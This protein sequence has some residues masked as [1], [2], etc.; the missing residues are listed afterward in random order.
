MPANLPAEARAKWIKVME[1]K[2]KEEKLRA[3]QEFLSC[4]PR[5]KGT[6]KLIKQVRR[7]IA[8]LRRE[9]EKERVKKSGRGVGHFVKKEGAAQVLLVGLTN[10]GKSTI[11]SKLTN[12][13]PKISNQPFTT[14][15]PVAGMMECDGV[16]FQLVEG[17]A[18][19][20]GAS[21]GV[22]YGNLTLAMARNA[23]VLALV[24]DLSYNPVYQ[25]KVI[26][27]ELKKSGIIL[28]KPSTVV[29]IKRRGKGG[30][31]IV[32]N[33]RNCSYKDVV[34]LLRNYGIHHAY[35]KITGEASLDDIEEAIQE[36][37]IYK[38]ALVIATK[39][40]VSGSE[41]RLNELKRALSNTPLL[42]F[43]NYELVKVKIKDMLLNMLDLI[44]VYTRNSV[45]KE[46]AEKPIIVKIGTT[47][48]EVARIIHSQLYEN[49][50]CAKVWRENFGKRPRRVGRNFVL[51][52][53]DIVE[54]I[55]R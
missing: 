51:E 21:D 5:H 9:L 36:E 13:S 7:Q 18:I 50:K 40:D 53:G 41:D 54:I 12:A 28:E 38:P 14:K 31:V 8:I 19:V 55:A 27:E 23:D 37:K 15:K 29:T 34:E 22:C 42:I 44:R 30:I 49:F 4:V 33:L 47:V 10:S 46:I 48:I 1:A 39:V 43:D 32:G 20:E 2:T 24:I 26:E 35:V 6:E 45:T 25:L 3:L 16:R 11:L 17:P 52:D